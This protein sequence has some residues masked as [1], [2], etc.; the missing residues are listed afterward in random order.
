MASTAIIPCS[1]IAPL[2]S[3]SSINPNATKAPVEHSLNVL[4]RSKSRVNYVG[5]RCVQLKKVS[6]S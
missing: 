6:V 3:Y 4:N 1:Y 2:Y 5:G